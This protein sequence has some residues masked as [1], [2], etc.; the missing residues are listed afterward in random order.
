[1]TVLIVACAAAVAGT[2]PVTYVY[3]SWLTFDAWAVILII[4]EAI[5]IPN[6]LLQQ[7]FRHHPRRDS[8][9]SLVKTRCR[10]EKEKSAK[11]IRY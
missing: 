4:T 2:L 10:L 7:L 5:E 8:F 3:S 6:R 1:M 11:S 9:K